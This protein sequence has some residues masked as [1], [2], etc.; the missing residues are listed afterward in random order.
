M[1]VL[2]LS[3]A[4]LTVPFALIPLSLS[5]RGR[6]D[7]GKKGTYDRARTRVQPS[8]G[9]H[10]SRGKTK[11]KGNGAKET[12]EHQPRSREISWPYYSPTRQ[13]QEA[14][15]AA[16][17]R[18]PGERNERERKD[19]SRPRPLLI[20]RQQVDLSR[21]FASGPPFSLSLSAS[22]GKSNEIH[23]CLL[24]AIRHPLSFRFSRFSGLAGTTTAYN[25]RPRS[26][27]TLES[28]FPCVLFP[29][30]GARDDNR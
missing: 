29:R 2:S 21:V 10:S 4:R 14:E 23:C 5:R 25:S 19:E 26:R 18:K 12:T 3:L 22:A 15:A 30:R 1:Y 16:G 6:G 11:R 28:V 17:H 7:G 8:R 9:L 24:G 27:G 13:R 20:I